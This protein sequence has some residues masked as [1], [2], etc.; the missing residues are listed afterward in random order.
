[1]E[2]EFIKN[3]RVRFGTLA[4]VKNEAMTKSKGMMRR[5]LRLLTV[6]HLVKVGRDKSRHP[7]VGIQISES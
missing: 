3:S 5:A 2:D 1:M 4:G 7:D 6:P